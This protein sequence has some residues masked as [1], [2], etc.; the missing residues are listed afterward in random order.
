MS[1]LLHTCPHNCKEQCTVLEI[2][3]L[4]EKEAILQYAALRD[5]CTYPEIKA[6]LNQ[7]II[8]RKHAIELL[9][10]TKSILKSKFDIL[11]QVRE[12]YEIA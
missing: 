10:R 5:E 9:E 6:I 11:D 12:G 2:A 1:T 4:R 8:E 7:L 3:S